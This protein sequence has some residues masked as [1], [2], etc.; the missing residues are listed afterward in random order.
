MASK[1]PHTIRCR[2][3]TGPVFLFLFLL[4]LIVL[5]G[6][7]GGG[8]DT[9]T[10]CEKIPRV[11]SATVGQTV[12]GAICSGSLKQHLSSDE[13][14]AIE[15][16][17]YAGVLADNTVIE[18]SCTVKSGS[19]GAKS[20]SLDY[21]IPNP[22][23]NA[24][25]TDRVGP[26]GTMTASCGNTSFGG[27]GGGMGG[28]TGNGEGTFS[29]CAQCNDNDACTID[30]CAGSAGAPQCQFIPRCLSGNCNAGNCGTGPSCGNGICEIAEDSS[31]CP[32]D[33]QA[34]IVCPDGGF[35]GADAAPRN[36]FA[37][38][39]SKIAANE[40]DNQNPGHSNCDMT[41][42]LIAFF[43]KMNLAENYLNG[44]AL[45]NRVSL[46]NAGILTPQPN[47]FDLEYN[48]AFLSDN[49][50]YQLLWDFGHRQ[51][52]FFDEPSWF[53]EKWHKYLMT[54]PDDSPILIEYNSPSLNSLNAIHEAGIYRVKIETRFNTA[55]NTF[56]S[57]NDLQPNATIKITLER[58][59]SL[60]DPAVLDLA[61]NGDLGLDNAWKDYG[62]QWE[63]RENQAPVT[64]AFA[65]DLPDASSLDSSRYRYGLG[66]VSILEAENQEP[67]TAPAF[68]QPSTIPA[69]LQELLFFNE[70]PVLLQTVENRTTT[71]AAGQSSPSIEKEDGVYF[72]PMSAV[73]LLAFVSPN[74]SI[75][76]GRTRGGNTNLGFWGPWTSLIEQATN[77]GNNSA[78]PV[79]NNEAVSC[80]E[81][82][83]SIEN[84]LLLQ[85]GAPNAKIYFN[86]DY[87]DSTNETAPMIELC[88]VGAEVASLS[89]VASAANQRVALANE[90]FR[91]RSIQE[92]L[93]GIKANTVC[94][95]TETV[96]SPVED[97]ETGFSSTQLTKTT[98]TF[99]TQALYNQ[100][101]PRLEQYLNNSQLGA[102]SYCG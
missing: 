72:K 56:F 71:T 30:N 94:V 68:F 26:D 49:L 61:L 21:L 45:S 90:S 1:K 25:C 88:N 55:Q 67:I 85:N 16:T 54:T 11:S 75:G 58:A 47:G 96:E 92:L 76:L 52:G 84:G 93:D 51:S 17:D 29:F 53:R 91:L 31:N 82:T 78:A 10:I 59:G 97:T 39:F 5:S 101:Q 102:F 43:K 50:S 6:C 4:L 41:Q 34:R 27:G 70:M 24:S 36:K 33:C 19:F 3:I 100:I 69:S 22:C 20:Y 42:F 44:N 32:N 99:N 38:T 87:T 57:G 74:T 62:I 98:Y 13:I 81:T 64:I 40:C 7:L 18:F 14:S 60:A 46:E 80:G 83:A 37:W 2:I 23:P 48:A 65:A 35:T 9:N 63:Q 95:S 86:L 8:F 77:C 15:K 73:P 66:F 89:D 28:G 79:L 12:A